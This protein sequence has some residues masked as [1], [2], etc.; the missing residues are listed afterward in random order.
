MSHRLALQ[1]AVPF[2]GTGH[3]LPQPPQCAV[4]LVV[5]TQFPEQAVSA[6]QLVLH[7]PPKHVSPT[8]Q[9]LPHC[10]QFAESVAVSTQPVLHFARPGSQRKSQTLASHVA[11]PNAGA[12]HA[13][14]QLPQ[15]CG[16][17]AV[18][19]QAPL[20]AVRPASHEMEQVLAEQTA[21]PFDG[22][23]HALPQSLQLSALLVT[24]THAPAHAFRPPG[25]PL[26]Q[27]KL[28]AQTSVTPQAVV[29]L[30]Q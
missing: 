7:A 16:S 13:V 28:G 9:T 3:P 29:Q 27:P 10:P 22:G 8:A 6:P 4:L 21:L 5:S 17:A 14:V 23:G 26:V 12:L 15:C 20:Q 30:P 24:S 2:A 11:V 19:T 18:S 1:T 25:Q